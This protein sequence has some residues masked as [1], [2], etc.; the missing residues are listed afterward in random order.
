MRQEI[1]DQKAF[2]L[3]PQLGEPT[4]VMSTPDLTREMDEVGSTKTDDLGLGL[5][6]EFDGGCL[7][8]E[9][10]IYSTDEDLEFGAGVWR[11]PA[12]D[13][14]AAVV[15]GFCYWADLPEGEESDDDEDDDEE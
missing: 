7:V 2:V 1:E 12:F 3:F 6:S 13:E 14:V 11:A 15:G 8:W 10:T 9:G 4:I 5:P